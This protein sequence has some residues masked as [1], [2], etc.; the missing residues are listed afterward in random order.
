M[1]N[2][3]QIGTIILSSLT[4]KDNITLKAHIILNFIKIVLDKKTR[5]YIYV[6]DVS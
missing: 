5:S 3:M 4:H 2:A 6:N 1:S